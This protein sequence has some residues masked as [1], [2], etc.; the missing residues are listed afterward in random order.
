[1]IK[2]IPA[3]KGTT[4]DG[5]EI[6]SAQAPGVYIELKIDDDPQFFVNVKEDGDSSVM[7]SF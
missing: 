7:A 4:P 1:M 2:Q 3:T 6:W 5:Y